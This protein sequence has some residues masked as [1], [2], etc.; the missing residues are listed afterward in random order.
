MREDRVHFPGRGMTGHRQIGGKV[1]A[2]TV[3][4]NVKRQN[5]PSDSLF[6]FSIVSC[7]ESFDTV[8]ETIV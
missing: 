1:A 5:N 3:R 8:L 2:R 4:L 7:N 6:P